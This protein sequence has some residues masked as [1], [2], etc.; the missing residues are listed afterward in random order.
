MTTKSNFTA[1]LYDLPYLRQV[2][3]EMGLLQTRG[4]GAGQGSIQQ[5]L[6]H[7][8]A[9]EVVVFLAADMEYNG[10]DAAA[11]DLERIMD[12]LHPHEPAAML[13][14]SLIPAARRAAARQRRLHNEAGD[15]EAYED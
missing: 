1:N 12:D 8:Q 15:F 13:L 14:A 3:A 5:L 10:L 6:N 9:G 2:A 11:G 4:P 7:V